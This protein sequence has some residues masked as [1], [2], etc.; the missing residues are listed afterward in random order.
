MADPFAPA[1]VLARAVRRGEVSPVELVRDALDRIAA[2]NPSL[3]AF[4]ALRPEAALAEAAALERRIAA[5]EEVGP[6]AGLPL[7]VKDLED[8]ADMPTTFGSVP[9]KKW[10]P[11]G[12]SVQVARL[13]RAGAIVVGKTNT[14]EFGYTALSKNLLFGVSRNPWN[15][16][17]TPGGSSG[18]SAAAIAAGMVP[19]VTA[20]DGGGSVRIPAC[21][22]GAFGLKPSFGRVPTGAREPGNMLPWVDTVCYGPI[23]R[24]VR[25]AALFLD[26]VAGVDPSDPDSLPAP[27]ISYEATLEQL[28]PGL[29]IGVSKTLGYGLVQ[30]DVWREVESAVAVLSDLG[31]HVEL[32]DDALPDLGIEWALVCSAETYA[33]LAPYIEEHRGEWG[34]AFLEGVERATATISSCKRRTPT[35][36][37]RRGTTG[38]RRSEHPCLGRRGG[39]DAGGSAAS[40]ADRRVRRRPRGVHDRRARARH[41]ER[42]TGADVGDHRLRLSHADQRPESGRRRTRRDRAREHRGARAPRS[43]DVW[44]AA[45]RPARASAL[46][47]ALRVRS[48]AHGGR[49]GDRAG[50]RRRRRRRQLRLPRAEGREEGRRRGADA[51]RPRPRRDPA[52]ASRRARD[53]LHREDSRRMG[54][55]VAER[56]RDR[57][58]RRGGGRGDDRRARPDA[59][60]ALHRPLGLGLDRRGEAGGAGAGRRQRR[61]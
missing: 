27:G 17:R 2:L 3:N 56:G 31:H 14:P 19:L 61:R 51:A 20:S 50:S 6:L 10:T 12:D 58:P 16:E 8:V 9:F 24:T 45:P 30:R 42:R 44:H 23:T 32:I 59:P 18:G 41:A 5:K 33:L 15:L 52:R 7:G 25:D 57:A 43:A 37:R 22:V 49:G 60:A 55:H 48:R 34:R 39:S 54:R 28:P 29:R 26:V 21:Y 4:A 47:P 13:K 40:R 11:R 53:S 38:G 35:S 46:D 1:Y 36:R